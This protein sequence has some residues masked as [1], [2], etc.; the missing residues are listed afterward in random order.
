MTGRQMTDLRITRHALRSV[1]ALWVAA[2]LLAPPLAV[3]GGE[4]GPI[5]LRDQGFFWVGARTKQTTTIERD[6]SKGSG[7]GINGQMYVGFQLVANKRHPYPLVLVHGGGG[8]ATDWMGTPDGRDG[9]LDYF[10]AA[11]FDVYF[12]DRPAHGRS[13]PSLFYG[14]KLGTPTTT[15]QIADAFTKRS[16]QYPGGGGADTKELAQ[17]TAS[18]E[19]GP[20]ASDALLQQDL[21]ELLDRIGPAILV[22]HSAGGRSAWLAT[23]AR[24]DK[25]KAVLAIEPAMGI[26]EE[27]APLIAFKPALAAGEKFKTVQG[28]AVG[29][30][31]PCVL[32]A[33]D[34]ARTVPAY[35]GKQ[36]LFVESP[37]SPFTD[38]VHCSVDLLN[39]LGANAKLAR[40]VDYG[41]NGNGHFMNEELNNG[42]IA[43]Q[44]F[45][46]FLSSIK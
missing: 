4:A 10:L 7:T 35:A 29:H 8:Q 38:N 34:S 15:Q 1:A 28:P 40:L 43:Q 19:P 23:A 6:G 3:A 24:P 17:H 21:A 27:L 18:S 5:S 9:W 22:V 2:V 26:I 31:D 16:K 44:V 20:T 14:E 39:Q 42:Q 36:I 46:P 41:I 13:P 25:V 11:G 45:I 32:Q 30:G 33:K 37:Q 12:V